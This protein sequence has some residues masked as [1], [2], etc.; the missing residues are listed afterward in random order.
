MVRLPYPPKE[1]VC[2]L[3]ARDRQ[4]A[5]GAMGERTHAV[6]FVAYHSDL[7]WNQ[8]WVVHEGEGDPFAAPIR[9]ALESVGCDLDLDR[10]D[11]GVTRT[12]HL[13]GA[14]DGATFA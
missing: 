2:V 10:F 5:V 12:E 3:L 1:V 7:L 4:S 9:E 6:V 14:V 11:P 13:P 8:G